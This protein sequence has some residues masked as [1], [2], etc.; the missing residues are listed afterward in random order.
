MGDQF[1]LLMQ[2]VDPDRLK[3]RLL[4]IMGRIS[5]IFEQTG[6]N[7]PIVLYAG[8]AI[9]TPSMAGEQA[10][11]TLLCIRLNLRSS[12]CGTGM[13]TWSP[14]IMT[15]CMPPTPQQ[16]NIESSMRYALSTGQFQMWLQ[17]KMDLQTGV[18]CGAE[19]LVR[20]V[21]PDGGMFYPNEFIPLFERNGFCTEFDLYM[22]ERACA[23]L[24]A[25]MDA[26]HPAGADLGQPVQTALL[27]E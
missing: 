14:S 15:T 7:Y 27:P 21:R 19:A 2:A 25:W 8:A 6:R 16:N 3:Q 24:R 17:P 5:G 4:G 22:V 13:K 1:Y 11:K 18:L 23:C 9:G 12:M 10:A 26:G 20:W